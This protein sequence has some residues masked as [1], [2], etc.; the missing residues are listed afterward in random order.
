MRVRLRDLAEGL[1]VV[2]EAMVSKENLMTFPACIRSAFLKAQICQRK[3]NCAQF[4]TQESLEVSLVS[5]SDVDTCSMLI[6][7]CNY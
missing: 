7:L 4:A 6:V 1:S 5:D 3:T 2:T